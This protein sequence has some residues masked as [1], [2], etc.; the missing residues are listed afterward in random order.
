MRRIKALYRSAA[1]TADGRIR[2]VDLD[3]FVCPHGTC[4]QVVDG[5]ELRVDGSHF[6]EQGA[7]VVGKELSQV[8][9]VCWHDPTTCR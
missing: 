5:V 4:T 2:V 1:P 9:L 7:K 8:L 6:S 3:R